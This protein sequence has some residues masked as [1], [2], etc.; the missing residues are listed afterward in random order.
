[1]PNDEWMATFDFYLTTPGHVIGPRDLQAA[2]H[3]SWAME[4]QQAC[5][6]RQLE[7]V[8]LKGNL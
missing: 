1:M 4:W 7:L 5:G 3:H 6:D 8:R 2:A